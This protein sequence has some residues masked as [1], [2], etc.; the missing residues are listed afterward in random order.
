M[1]TEA[2]V[3]SMLGV[4]L[5]TTSIVEHHCRVRAVPCDVSSRAEATQRGRLKAAFFALSDAVR[6]FALG[7]LVLR[8]AG[9]WSGHSTTGLAGV[10][11]A[12]L[13]ATDLDRRVGEQQP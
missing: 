11:T 2:V 4:D 5:S 7:G 3:G 8:P 12:R 13:A 10:S 9:R 1:A 6:A